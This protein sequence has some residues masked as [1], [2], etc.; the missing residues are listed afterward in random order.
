MR[1]IDLIEEA[2]YGPNVINKINRVQASA[3]SVFPGT[4]FEHALP[5][6]MI[7]EF[8]L[9]RKYLLMGERVSNLLIN[10]KACLMED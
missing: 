10:L 7:N 8:S 2:G 9:P 3:L 1:V 4:Q 6:T 5:R